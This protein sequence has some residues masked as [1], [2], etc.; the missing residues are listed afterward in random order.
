[1]SL[2]IKLDNFSKVS[3]QQ[4]TPAQKTKDL[5]EKTNIDKELLE[6]NKRISDIDLAIA[7]LA[8]REKDGSLS[9]SESFKQQAVEL[10]KKVAEYSKKSVSFKKI[11]DLTKK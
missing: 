8:K 1:M 11:E 10:Q 9:R 6:I 5:Q 4:K 7:N 3:E 2:I